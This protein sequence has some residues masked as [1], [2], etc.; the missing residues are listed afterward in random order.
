M[1]NESPDTI[2]GRMKSKFRASNAT[3]CF[4]CDADCGPIQHIHH[5]VPRQYGGDNGPTLALCPN[6]HAAVHVLANGADGAACWA[7]QAYSD[8]KLDKLFELSASAVD[9]AGHLVEDLAL[10]QMERAGVQRL[11]VFGLGIL[12]PSD[13]VGI[14]CTT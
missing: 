4:V 8:S 6:C 3:K 5:V 2:H 7:K 10:Y 1:T 9:P 12:E 14:V 13:F 11:H